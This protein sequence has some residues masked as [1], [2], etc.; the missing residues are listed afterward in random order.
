MEAM[1]SFETYLGERY[2]LSWDEMIK[3]HEMMLVEIQNDVDAKELY[4]DVIECA[5]RYAAYRA[6]W[7]IWSREKQMEHDESRSM[8]HD[9]LITKFDILARYLRTIGCQAEWRESLGDVKKDPTY[10]KR[11]GDFACFLVFINSL[12]MR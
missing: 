2:S 3:C 6:N 7:G 11:I 10:R 9:S 12:S 4:G 1:N 8:C 5:T